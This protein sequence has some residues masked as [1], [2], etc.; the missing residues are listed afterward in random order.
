M[1]PAKAAPIALAVAAL[2]ALLP[3][4]PVQGEPP[5]KA[6]KTCEGERATIVGKDGDDSR[7]KGTKRD[8][9][10]V[11]RGGSDFIDAK[12]GDDLICAGSGADLVAGGSGDDI[13]NGDP[14]NDTLLGDGGKDDL[15]G[16]EGDDGIGGGDGRGDLCHGGPGDDRATE[17]GCERIQS[18]DGV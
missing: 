14:G 17:K 6:A 16:K 4:S 8:D 9:V 1:S 11:G 10:I 18:A 3:T 2:A 5:A 13:A 12:G 7:L 15:F